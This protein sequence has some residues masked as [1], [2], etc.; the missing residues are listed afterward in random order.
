MTKHRV[1]TPDT[2]DNAMNLLIHLQSE[3]WGLDHM[4][5]H[6]EYDV[7]TKHGKRIPIGIIL[8]VGLVPP[9]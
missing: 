8:T 5:E 7:S 2:L 9:R 3:G 4:E 6:V 1:E